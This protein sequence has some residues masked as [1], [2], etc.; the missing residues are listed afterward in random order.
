ML[1]PRPQYRGRPQCSTCQGSPPDKTSSLACLPRGSS[2]AFA[3]HYCCWLRVVLA[4]Q[5]LVPGCVFRIKI[6]SD[7][8]LRLL[9][10]GLCTP[11]STSARA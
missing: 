1:T 4:I 2:Q 10:L 6:L 9:P 3:E 11:N 5:T 8:F 7:E